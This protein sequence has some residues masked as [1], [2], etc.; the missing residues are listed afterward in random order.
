MD[1]SILLLDSGKR[2]ISS[3][4]LRNVEEAR[5]ILSPERL[6]I[7]R[8]LARKPMYPRQIASKLGLSEPN[9]Y[10]HF[11]LLRKCGLIEVD[12][13]E[14]RRG[15]TATYYRVTA[16][17][18]S[19]ILNE[20]AL[21]DVRR[22]YFHALPEAQK[23]LSSFLDFSDVRII[24][25]SP[26]P[27]GALRARARDIHH[28]IDL[29][30]FLGF[31]SNNVDLVTRLDTEVSSEERKFNLIIVGGPIVNMVAASINRLL[32]IKFDITRENIIVSD[33]SGKEYF[34]DAHGVVEI[35]ENPYNPNAKILLVAG[36][37]RTGTRAAV[38]ALTKKL[39][40]VCEGNAFNK[41]V[42]ARVVLGID[43]DSDGIIDTVEIVE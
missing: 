34:E 26:D 36:K 12:H 24:V 38:I 10:Y 5:I 1:D 6:R 37:R 32:P 2:A 43:E 9:V 7:L 35:I 15:T 17:A 16:D 25:G 20:K 39:S 33:V 42:L 13:V 27:H 11:N 3:S 14:K 19:V 4:L 8:V 18:V 40:E 23:L 41:D 21:T 22:K 30:L 31:L 29:A 28:A